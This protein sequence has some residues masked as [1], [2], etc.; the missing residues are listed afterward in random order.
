MIDQ[1]DTAL[2]ILDAANRGAYL[3]ASLGF[4]ECRDLDGSEA[5]RFLVSAG[6]T[7]LGN[8]DKGT[9]GEAW[10]AEGVCLST[11]GYCHRR[12]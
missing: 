12:A 10:T 3:P 8:A 1:T 6:F 9:H 4:S 2:T 5:R 11:N 7:V